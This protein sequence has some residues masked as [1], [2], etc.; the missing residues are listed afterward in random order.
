MTRG[1]TD[2]EGEKFEKWQLLRSEQSL[3]TNMPN[4]ELKRWYLTSISTFL[5]ITLV[6]AK[7]TYAP[8][9]GACVGFAANRWRATRR[10]DRIIPALARHGS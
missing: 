4:L 3:H 1:D 8:I 10:M 2:R 6:S 9:D 7:M 5:V